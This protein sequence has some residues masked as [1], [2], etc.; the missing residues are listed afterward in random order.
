MPISDDLTDLLA[1]KFCD[2]NKGTEDRYD[3]HEEKRAARA[4]VATD[5]V[6][7]ECTRLRE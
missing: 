3:V 6:A 7:V 4:P 2:K 5:A 1:L